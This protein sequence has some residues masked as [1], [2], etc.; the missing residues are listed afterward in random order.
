MKSTLDHRRA[1]RA[2]QNENPAFIWLQ[3]EV[4]GEDD[5]AAYNTQL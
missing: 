4:S 2:K 1:I 3:S 5:R